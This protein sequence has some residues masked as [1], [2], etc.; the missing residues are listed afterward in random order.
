[1]NLLNCKGMHLP[2]P[3]EAIKINTKHNVL[4]N[5]FER[6]SH[7]GFL[8]LVQMMIHFFFSYCVSGCSNNFRVAPFPWDIQ[9]KFSFSSNYSLFSQI[10]LL[11]RGSGQPKVS[12]V[13]LG[14]LV[15]TGCF[16]PTLGAKRLNHVCRSQECFSI[17]PSWDMCC[18]HLLTHFSEVSKAL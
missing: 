16:S 13:S 6:S 10:L 11:R 5:W 4:G 8:H 12:Y 18:H 2:S 14:L 3:I 17:I 15:G 9:R 7:N 1:M